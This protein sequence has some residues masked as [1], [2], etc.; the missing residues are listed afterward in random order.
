M[1]KE[2]RHKFILKEINLHNKVLSTDLRDQLIVSEDT[3]R[4]D[5]NELADQGLIV[6]VYGGAMG[7]TFHYPFNGETQVYALEAKQVIADKTLRLFR[8]GMLILMEGGTTIMEIAK[9]IPDD[10]E[11]TVFTVS[12]QV[13][14][15]LAY[16]EKLEVIVIG[17]RLAKNSNIH[18]G[19]SVINELSNIKP[20]LCVIGA[21]GISVEDGITDSDWEVV[22]VNKAMIRSAKKVALVSIAE[23][24]GTVRKLKI[25]D[26]EN[27]DYI[28][29]ELTPGSPELAAYD[30]KEKPVLL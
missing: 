23:K 18:T 20:D 2:E 4:R 25:T 24:F 14:L 22:Q 12:P 27:I 5:L 30:G 16:H 29:T 7:R 9:R 21:N 26:I 10:L 8:N 17:G 3:I 28:I 1:L 6:K 13:A 19:A 15:T 11:A